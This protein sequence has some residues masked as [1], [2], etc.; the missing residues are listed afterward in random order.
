M[1]KRFTARLPNVKSCCFGVRKMAPA[2]NFESNLG[3]TFPIAFQRSVKT[4]ATSLIKSVEVLADWL[5]RVSNCRKITA[6]SAASF[7]MSGDV[8]AV[9]RRKD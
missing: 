6:E 7:I 3:V 5:Y 2:I 8:D 1:K 9:L 4:R